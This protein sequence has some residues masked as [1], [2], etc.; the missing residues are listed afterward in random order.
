MFISIRAKLLSGTLALLMLFTTA[1][2]I[3]LYDIQSLKGSIQTAEQIPI[4]ISRTSLEAEIQIFQLEDMEDLYLIT[5]DPVQLQ[6][7]LEKIGTSEKKVVF[8]CN[9]IIRKTGP[10]Q[11]KI[12]GIKV[13]DDFIHSRSFRKTILDMAEDKSKGNELKRVRDEKTALNKQIEMQLDQ[14]AK[15]ANSEGTLLLN[16]ATEVS[17]RNRVVFI[18]VFIFSILLGSGIS[19]VSSRSVSRRLNIISDATTRMAQGDL[20][21]S[22]EVTEN[23]ELSLVSRNF[24]R[25][26][27]ELYDLYHSL[28]KK[29]RERTKELND[30]NESLAKMKNELEIKVTERTTDLEMKV[31]ELN[32]SQKALL[33]MVEDLNRTSGKLKDAQEE[34]VRKERLA[35]L[36]EFSGNISHELRNPLGVIDSSI[37]F[38]KMSLQNKDEKTLQ[39]LERISN[40]VKNSISIIEN[41]LNLTRMNKP[42]LVRFDCSR[43]ITDCL[44][45]CFIPSTVHVVKEFSEE[46]ITI[47]AESIQFQM[48][49]NNLVKNAISAMNE[50]G[51][52][53]IKIDKSRPEEAAI[54]FSDSG[55]GIEPKNLEKI[56]QPL[57]STK[58]KGFGLGL[59]ITKMIV[60]NHGGRIYVE[61]MPGM[62][63]SFIMLFPVL[64]KNRQL[65]NDLQMTS[66]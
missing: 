51:T 36:G 39:H 55:S 28:E 43:L 65:T 59:S 23:D 61:S 58:A 48:V 50:D 13:L 60:E 22:I 5:N 9:S 63:S 3:A 66:S 15:N 53:T 11:N 26:A 62:G 35:I 2:I 31:Q 40:S 8:L 30:A 44:N 52:L 17:Q 32:K 1:G 64:D 38:L 14:I 24:N 12:L 16:K 46:Q 56:F 7:L 47:L 41:L 25:M 54:S 29:V 45:S 19:I 42:V 6:E 34:L 20:K 57:F 49:V 10:G 37:Y 21:Q 27:I 33:Y 18:S 4:F